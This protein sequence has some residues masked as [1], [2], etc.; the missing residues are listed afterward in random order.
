MPRLPTITLREV[1]RAAGVSTAS[2]SRALSGPGVGDALRG[3]ILAAAKRLGYTPNLAARSLAERR[4]RLVGIVLGPFAD[5]LFTEVVLALECQLAAAGYGALISKARDSAEESRRALHELLGRGAEALVLVEVADAPALA[6][7][8]RTRGLPCVNLGT[9]T[10][11]AEAVVHN[12]CRRGAGLAGRYLLGLGHRRVGVIAAPTTGTAAGVA[13]ALAEAGAAAPPSATLATLS[14]LLARHDRPTAFVCGS[15]LLALALVRACR[16]HGLTVPA[17]VSVIGFGDAPFA[18]C[19]VPALSTLRIA[20][21]GLGVRLAESL[22]A[23]L[24]DGQPLKVPEPQVKLV[25]REST[26]PAPH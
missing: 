10:D 24:D 9:G 19:S 23:C 12:G 25:V 8:A 16:E 22:L 11:G 13:E 26:G 15:D 6:V 17:D 21:T 14:A 3:R 18:R 5:P 2:A 20:A 1:A 7:E 4:A